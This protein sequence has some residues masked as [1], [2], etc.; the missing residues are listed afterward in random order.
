MHIWREGTGDGINGNR[1]EG[2]RERREGT[3]LRP[4]DVLLLLLHKIV[5]QEREGGEVDAGGERKR[6]REREGAKAG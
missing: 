5:E 4:T 2:E 3:L 6:E 1:K